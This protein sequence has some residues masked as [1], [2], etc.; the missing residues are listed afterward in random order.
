[1]LRSCF[2][3]LHFWAWTV[4][5]VVAYKKTCNK[6]F[7]CFPA[8]LLIMWLYL[9]VPLF[10]HNNI[11]VP[12]F[13][14]NQEKTQNIQYLNNHLY[15]QTVYFLKMS[16]MYFLNNCVSCIIFKRKILF[17]ESRCKFS[18]KNDTLMTN[19]LIAITW[20]R[21]IRKIVL[22]TIFIHFTID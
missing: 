5:N 20:I 11:V 19:I 8:F 18:Y 7:L 10:F 21:G 15:F 6:L 14:E 3:F 17:W 2:F 9:Q 1:M 13:L 16:G 22:K 12:M 4:S